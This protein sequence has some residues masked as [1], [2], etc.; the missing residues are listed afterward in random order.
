[1]SAL[2]SLTRDMPALRGPATT[3]RDT[4]DIQGTYGRFWDGAMALGTAVA[5]LMHP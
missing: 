4:T 1:V 5:L 2:R 3:A